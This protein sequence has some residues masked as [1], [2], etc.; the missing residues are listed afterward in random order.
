MLRQ[1]NT[2]QG[3]EVMGGIFIGDVEE[4]AR[5]SKEKKAGHSKGSG[6]KYFSLLMIV[7]AGEEKLNYEFSC[8]SNF[9]TECRC[10]CLSV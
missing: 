4:P 2:G 7:S 9:S 6:W 8:K 3:G 1:R 5:S 10:K